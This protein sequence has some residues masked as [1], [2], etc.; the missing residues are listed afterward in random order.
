VLC[1]LIMH[2]TFKFEG[3]FF[4]AILLNPAKLL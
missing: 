4:L 3:E 2:A 1:R